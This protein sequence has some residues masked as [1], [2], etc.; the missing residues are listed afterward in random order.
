MRLFEGNRLLGELGS[1]RQLDDH[2]VIEHE[3]PGKAH[4]A[5]PARARVAD[6][7]MRRRRQQRDAR[8]GHA[9]ERASRRDD[10]RGWLGL[11]AV[12]TQRRQ[13]RYG[14]SSAA[15]SDAADAM[16]GLPAAVG[17]WLSFVAAESDAA[18]TGC[19]GAGGRTSVATRR[20]T[21]ACIASV[22]PAAACVLLAVRNASLALGNEDDDV[23]V[24]PAA[25]ELSASDDARCRFGR[26]A[27][28]ENGFSLET[29]SVRV[30]V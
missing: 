7:A 6:A 3:A 2:N 29:A 30:R 16:L 24:A 5:F 27:D 20:I 22:A 25:L 11:D 13:R 28:P 17:G 21:S 26:G 10:R 14:G 9:R 23:A 4:S 8:D 12:A 1:A 18:H 15:R 19:G